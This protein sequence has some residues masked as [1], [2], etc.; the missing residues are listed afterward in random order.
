MVNAK[1]VPKL[2]SI[3]GRHIIQVVV[4]EPHS[5]FG[6][7]GMVSALYESVYNIPAIPGI[8]IP[9]LIICNGHNM[10]SDIRYIKVSS[11]GVVMFAR[12]EENIAM[13]EGDMLIL[14]RGY[15]IYLPHD[16]LSAISCVLRE[17]MGEEYA[18]RDKNKG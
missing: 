14:E 15:M 18:V 1:L 12:D 5:K 17:N 4:G 6:L 3:G 8:A 9:K 13:Y 11:A 16:V 2:Q 7:N 10:S